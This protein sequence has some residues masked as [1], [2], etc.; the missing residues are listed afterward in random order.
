M[1]AEVG[2]LPPT[3]IAFNMQ[4]VR[5]AD[6]DAPAALPVSKSGR[7][8]RAAAAALWMPTALRLLSSYLVDESVEVRL[9]ELSLHSTAG[10]HSPLQLVLPLLVLPLLFQYLCRQASHHICRYAQASVVP[11]PTRCNGNRSFCSPF[12][13][14]CQVH[15]SI[16]SVCR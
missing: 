15:V 4:N 16:V 12:P 10:R 5:G 2:P 14:A 8:N 3:T 13:L 9:A 1:L 7:K 6:A 11:M